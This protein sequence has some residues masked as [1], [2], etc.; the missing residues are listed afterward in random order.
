MKRQFVEIVVGVFVIAGFVGLLFLS[1]SVSNLSSD[2]ISDPYQVSAR[3]D[4]IGGL[5]VGAPV[6]MAGVT[7]G[8]VREIALDTDSFQ[9]NI[10]MDISDEYSRLPV[11]SSA[12]IYTQGLLGEQFVSLEPGGEQNYL[13]E[14]D[15]LRLTQSAVILENLI[16]QL[17]F[18]N[19]AKGA[20]Q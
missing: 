18:N 16:G 1:F 2:T 5:K 11:D 14:G 3:F 17:L 8:R 4:N 10:V 6:T 19:S 9:A 15:R 12:S 20:K 13:K 7:I